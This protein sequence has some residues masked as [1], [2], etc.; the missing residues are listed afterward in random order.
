MR[1]IIC[2]GRSA[3]VIP[4]KDPAQLAEKINLLL[5]DAGLRQTLGQQGRGD[6]LEKFDWQVI[7]SQYIDLI[8][9]IT[10]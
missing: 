7:T 6:V 8:Q 3:L 10:N 2:N 4:G 1:D 5:D 9:S